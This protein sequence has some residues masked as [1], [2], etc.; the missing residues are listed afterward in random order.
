MKIRLLKD[1]HG[2]K[3]G[4]I[5]DAQKRDR[6]VY[7]GQGL[8]IE[9]DEYEVIEPQDCIDIEIVKSVLDLTG[10]IVEAG[11][12]LKAYRVDGQVWLS[13]RGTLPL[14]EDSYRVIEDNYREFHLMGHLVIQ[15]VIPVDYHVHRCS[16][17][18]AVEALVDIEGFVMCGE[19]PV[20]E[21]SEIQL[22]EGTWASSRFV[23]EI[24]SK[25]L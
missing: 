23:G 3:K 22:P 15:L 18:E 14:A 13:L 8:L 7:I 2:L 11:T 5:L 4:T 10:T 1:V 17:E 21:Y 25:E 16:A 19:V 6:F 9:A 24:E 12:K 20:E